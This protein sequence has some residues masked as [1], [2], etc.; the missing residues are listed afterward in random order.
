MVAI[1]TEGTKTQN[2]KILQL[3]STIMRI[4]SYLMDYVSEQ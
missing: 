2:D 1:K 4:N 3:H